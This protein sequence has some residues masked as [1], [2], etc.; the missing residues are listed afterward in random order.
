M[1]C[2]PFKKRQAARPN[3]IYTQ[4]SEF[5]RFFLCDRCL[6]FRNDAQLNS[7][8]M[9]KKQSFCKQLLSYRFVFPIK[10]FRL[11]LDFF[12]FSFFFDAKKN[13]IYT[14]GKKA[15]EHPRISL[16]HLVTQPLRA[17]SLYAYHSSSRYSVSE[18]RTK[19]PIL[20][21]RALLR[22]AHRFC[23]KSHADGRT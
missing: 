1:G 19:P 4:S 14:P 22:A 13:G 16:S 10:T 18:G 12:S 21:K 20:C 2:R 7:G 17:A 5:S 11:P 3:K 6:L 23:F 15:H 9:I 8:N